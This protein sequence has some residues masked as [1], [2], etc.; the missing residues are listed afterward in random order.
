MNQRPTEDP[1]S[2]NETRPTARG[3]R[4]ALLGIVALAILLRVGLLIFAERSAA[5]F[6]FPDSHRYLRVARNIVAGLGPIDSPAVRSGT[7]PIY[8]IILAAGIRLG[9]ESDASMMRFGRIVNAAASVFSVACLALIGVRLFGHRVGLIAGTILAID[10]ILLFFN[11][12]VLTETVYV[13]TL[14]AALLAL[15][16]V[17]GDR[18]PAGRGL[19]SGMALGLGTL[20]RSTAIFLPLFILPAAWCF[21]PRRVRPVIL[22]GLLFGVALV[23]SPVVIRNYRLFGGFVPVRTGSGPSMLEAL[24]PW[25]DGSP[26]MDRI[27]YPEMPQSADERERDHYC[28]RAAWQWVRE[29]PA[30]AIRLAFAK[31]RRTWSPFM[32]A[33]G[34]S[35][36]IYQAVSLATVLPVYL[37]AAVGAWLLRG[38][39]AVLA[40]LLMPAVYFT[41]VHMVFVGSVRYRVP[42]MPLLFLLAGVALERLVLSLRSSRGSPQGA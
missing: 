29:H 31:L 19:A 27:E 4:L 28:Q 1:A 38:R 10:P 22:L 20:T 30:E 25:A 32:H 35:S 21:S 15:V 37:L 16:C 33:P 3:F 39:P 18:G 34:H 8:P 40:L 9:F 42:A 13:A 12:L 24:G 26:G 11:A 41:L 17:S 6:D 7:D 23:M 2:P 36:G 5:T 14:L